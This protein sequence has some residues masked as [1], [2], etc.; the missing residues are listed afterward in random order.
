MY[1]PLVFTHFDFSGHSNNVSLV[2]SLTSIEHVSPC[3]P[4]RQ[5]Q[6]PYIGSHDFVFSKRQLHVELH[7]GPNF[8][9]SQTITEKEFPIIFK[10][11]KLQ[12]VLIYVFKANKL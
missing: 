3:Q 5:S 11:I 4:V 8:V 6:S 1:D 10:I 7:S 9:F 12:L 2:H